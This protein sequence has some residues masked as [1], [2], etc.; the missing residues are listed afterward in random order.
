VSRRNQATN[1]ACFVVLLLPAAPGTAHAQSASSDSYLQAQSYTVRSPYGSPVVSR[2]RFTQT[3][4][5]G[6][7]DV[8]GTGLPGGPQLSI[9]TRMR[10]DA[11]L[12]QRTVDRDPSQLDYYIPGLEE[13]PMDLMV[14]YVDARNY[15]DGW[16]GAR[17]GRQYVIDTLGWWSFDGGLVSIATPIFVRFEAYGGFE[18]RGGLPFMSTPRFEADGVYR[19]AR[20]GLEANQWP[21][22]LEQSKLAPAFGFAM[23]SMDTHWLHARLGYRK[24]FN[25]DRVS[26]TPFADQGGAIST[27]DD[28]RVSS[29]RLGGS[30]WLTEAELGE[31]TASGVYDLF[32]QLFSQHGAS[33]GWYATSRITL[34]LGY[35]YFL[36]TFDGDSIFNWFTHWATTTYQGRGSWQLS[37]RLG[38]SATTGVRQFRTDGDPDTYRE[39]TEAWTAAA[40][41]RGETD[42][43]SDVLATLAVQYGWADGSVWVTGMGE[44]GGSG[45]RLGGDVSTRQQFEGGLYDTLVVL[46]VQDWRDEL[47]TDRDA[48]SFG[49]VLGGGVS[50]LQRAR[51]GLEWEHSLNRLVGQRFRLLGTLAVA[52][53]P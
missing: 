5:L 49:Y 51:L 3:L 25:R 27:V 23:E 8:T 32:N 48:T 26:V 45:H 36:P 21:S 15:L 11:D 24:V 50:P 9:V 35:D 1:A 13:T 14:A 34:G 19:G 2:R 38:F 40:S 37:R 44:A 4:G 42:I 28:T 46:S 41:P 52:V 12:G 10:L 17:L 6:V 39:Q 29:E 16:L 31:V 7:Y 18:Q 33:V 47:R 20:D 53:L 43:R 30:M 22:Y